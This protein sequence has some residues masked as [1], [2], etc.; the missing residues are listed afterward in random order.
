MLRLKRQ[1][2]LE[3]EN[4][5]T[6]KLLKVILHRLSLFHRDTNTAI[7]FYV[8]SFSILYAFDVWYV[9]VFSARRVRDANR[10]AVCEYVILLALLIDNS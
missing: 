8:S 10:I 4:F 5:L 3:G 7:Q 2:S 9:D 1:I 6:E